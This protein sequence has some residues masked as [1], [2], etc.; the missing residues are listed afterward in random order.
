[1]E[2]KP[3]AFA[4]LDILGY[5][6]L[7]ARKPEEVLILVQELLKS[8]VINRLVQH[9]LD[10]VARFSEA[11]TSPVIEY[12]QFSDT[13]MIYLRE[14]KL[15]PEQLAKPSQLV[16]SVCYATSLTLA[17]FIASGIPLRGAVGFGPT[18]I[19]QNPLF[20]TG[21]ELYETFKLER[22]QLWA[23]AGLH[24]SAKEALGEIQECSF[25]TEYQVPMTDSNKCKPEL[26]IDW[27]SCLKLGSDIVPPWDAMFQGCDPEIAIKREKT[28]QFYKSVGS[29]P[30][31]VSLGVAKET[32][33]SMRRRL[34]CLRA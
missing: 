22:E 31:P 7:M 21:V 10:E 28:I 12:L 19:S 29:N 18:F 27:V 13:L 2:S 24:S 1:M 4:V 32:I 16:E 9:D 14:Y 6:R 23:G 17:H 34:L 15:G 3:T 11:D 25:F 20:F 8:S 33:D 30:R 26:A 5:G